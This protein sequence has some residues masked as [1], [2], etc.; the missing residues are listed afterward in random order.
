M[1]YRTCSCGIRHFHGS[2]ESA[3]GMRSIFS[4]SL[5]SEIFVST[6]K[7]ACATQL[8]HFLD[9]AIERSGLPFSAAADVFGR[10]HDTSF[11]SYIL[12]RVYL[13]YSAVDLHFSYDAT[14]P[15]LIPSRLCGKRLDCFLEQSQVKLYK[16]F[17]ESWGKRHPADCS[18]A[19]C[20]SVLACDCDFKI[21]RSLC[22]VADIVISTPLWLLQTG[23]T[24][25]P[26]LGQRCCREHESSDIS[27]NEPKNS[28]MIT[29]SQ[30]LPGEF[31][32][33]SVLER[34]L[35]SKKKRGQVCIG[36]CRRL[37]V[38]GSLVRLRT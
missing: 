18:I 11:T 13:L 24:H 1:Y 12:E 9:N 31:I 38:Q 23:C 10:L 27:V 20:G 25:T 8:L 3:T 14:A 30:L 35:I 16:N 15:F 26:M 32:V 28:N 4:S 17:V 19:G 21:R 37:R 22:K 34:R 36:E 29:R 2:S 6:K 33:E 7:T 5:E